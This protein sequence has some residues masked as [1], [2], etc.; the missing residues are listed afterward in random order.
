MIDVAA[1]RRD[2]EAAA[3]KMGVDPDWLKPGHPVG[4]D[5]KTQEYWNGHI[6]WMWKQFLA[7]VEARPECWVPYK[8]WMRYPLALYASSDKDGRTVLWMDNPCEQYEGVWGYARLIADVTGEVAPF[9]G[10][11]RDSPTRRPKYQK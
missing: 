11:W 3:V 9:P 1:V 8:I 4:F 7:M 2:F 5:E 6:Q 10:D